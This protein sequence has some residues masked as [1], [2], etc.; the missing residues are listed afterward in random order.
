[1]ESK[2]LNRAF[3]LFAALFR[4]PRSSTKKRRRENSEN[5]GSKHRR[6]TK[7]AVP[8]ANH[9][10]SISERSLRNL[11]KRKEQI[12][13]ELSRNWGAYTIFKNLKGNHRNMQNIGLAAGSSPENSKLQ[14]L[15]E[16]YR[17]VRRGRN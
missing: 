17:N 7:K 14:S 4:M 8:A 13:R 16:S 3:E 6:I 15:L 12:K 1:M 10:F 5:N 11:N 9:G 2:L